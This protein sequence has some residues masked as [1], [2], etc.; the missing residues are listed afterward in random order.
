VTLSEEIA[1]LPRGFRPEVESAV[2]YWRQRNGD[3]GCVELFARDIDRQLARYGAKIRALAQQYATEPQS[4]LAEAEHKIVALA[5]R[6]KRQARDL[7]TVDFPE[8]A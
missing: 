6:V 2:I 3:A 1:R 5:E 7:Q 8:Y 4:Q